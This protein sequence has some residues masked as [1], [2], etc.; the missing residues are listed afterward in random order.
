[1]GDQTDDLGQLARGTAVLA[2]CIVQ[3]LN[4]SDPTFQERF[5][6]TLTEA[7]Y[8]LR[9]NSPRDPGLGLSLLAYARELLTG[10]NTVD[11]QGQPFLAGRLDGEG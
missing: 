1:M 5:L 10:F 3:T 11:G 9:D 7:Q 4:R 8:E 6:R 2:T